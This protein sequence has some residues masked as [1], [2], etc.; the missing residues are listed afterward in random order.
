MKVEKHLTQEMN[1]YRTSSMHLRKDSTQTISPVDSTQLL[2]S[3]T[4][5]RVIE[6]RNR[7]QRP[8]G[9]SHKHQCGYATLSLA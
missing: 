7:L 2:I 4:T 8:E 9:E 5:N 6:L 3:M 1:K